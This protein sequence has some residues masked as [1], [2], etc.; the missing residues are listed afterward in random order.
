MKAFSKKHTGLCR[1]MRMIFHPTDYDHAWVANIL[2]LTKNWMTSYAL[3]EVDT[4]NKRL[5]IKDISRVSGVD[6][7]T[8]T[9][10]VARDNQVCEGL[11]WS[12]VY[13]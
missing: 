11:G 9:E 6:G 13:E 2:M 10:C 8:S 3:Y 5:V 12:V 7:F 1:R 4:E